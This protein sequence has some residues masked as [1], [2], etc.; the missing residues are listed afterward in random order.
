MNDHPTHMIN[1]WSHPPYSGF[2]ELHLALL[3]AQRLVLYRGLLQDKAV[4]G[5]IELL[6]TLTSYP[7]TEIEILNAYHQF[8]HE[9]MS[10]P[11]PGSWPDAWQRYLVNSILRDEN[12]FSRQVEYLAWESI[13]PAWREAAGHD[14]TCLHR[15]FTASADAVRQATLERLG[16]EGKTSSPQLISWGNM[17]FCEQ[18]MSAAAEAL[19]NSFDWG[20]ELERVASHYRVCG[21]G[22]FQRFKSFRWEKEGDEGH[23]RGIERPDLV[24][25]R[26][27]IGLQLQK[28]ELEKNTLHFLAGLPA[29]HVLLYGPRGTGKTSLIKSLLTSFQARGL[30]II[31]LPKQHL[32]DIP[33]ILDLIRDRAHRFLLFIDDLSFEEHELGYKVLKTVLEGGMERIPA[34]VR[35]YATSNRRHLVREFFTDREADP[36]I[37]GGDTVQEKL[38][39]ADRFGITIT[40][41]WPNQ[42]SYMEIVRGLA[43]QRGLDPFSADLDKRALQWEK[44]HSGPSGRTARQFID[45]LTAESRY[46]S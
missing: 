17:V 8:I 19:F 11:E 27:L 2:N 39:I 40:F 5:Y 25:V 7:A 23:L 12:P 30:R 41:P 36:E 34:N 16:R 46:Q 22:L 10:R 43:R 13:S 31:E 24:N 26:D 45:H 3:A 35:I 18:E 14:L 15:L 44:S 9:L 29:N 38:S 1:D 6:R 21:T 42:S 32:A 37:H 33:V 20:G 4:A 28:E